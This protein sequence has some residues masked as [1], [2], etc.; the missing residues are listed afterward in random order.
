[1]SRPQF[2]YWAE[3]PTD[4]AIARVLLR[5]AGAEPGED[6]ASRRSTHAGK[7]ALRTK[8]GGLNAAAAFRPVLILRDF[9]G[10][11]PCPG[12]LVQSLLAVPE[13][14]MRLRI[15]VRSC[16]A[17]LLA[18]CD[19]FAEWIGVQPNGIPAEPET[20]L[21]AKSTIVQ[22]CR[23]SRN[24]DRKRDIL[25]RAGERVGQGYAI[26]LQE[27]VT[28]RWNPVRAASTGRSR[29]LESALKRIAEVKVIGAAR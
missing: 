24:R 29:S 22:L 8:I 28:Q 23:R 25:P 7:H 13:K 14:L 4:R 18:D 26:A 3:G 5:A 1:M 6:F 21:D 20:L 2:I 9:D 10:D 19:A 15:V 27:F 12:E 11:A 16:E 17:W